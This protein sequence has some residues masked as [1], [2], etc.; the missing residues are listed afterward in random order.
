MQHICNVTL[1]ALEF[2]FELFASMIALLNCE[3]GQ[4][5]EVCFKVYILLR[6]T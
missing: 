2:E 1:K 4:F 6:N 3:D 5:Q